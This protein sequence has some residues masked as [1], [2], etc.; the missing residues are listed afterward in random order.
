[1]SF[2]GHV[3]RPPVEGSGIYLPSC[4]PKELLHI[5]GIFANE[6]LMQKIECIPH[7]IINRLDAPLSYASFPEAAALFQVEWLSMLGG[8]HKK[9]VLPESDTED[10]V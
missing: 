10:R 4:Y 7:L 1:M 5:V 6:Y 3:Q 9:V 8:T 2:I